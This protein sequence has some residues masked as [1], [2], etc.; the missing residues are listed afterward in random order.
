MK[1]PQGGRWIAVRVQ[2]SAGEFHI[3]V[4]HRH[5]WRSLLCCLHPLLH[6]QFL[7]QALLQ[8]TDETWVGGAGHA[9]A[10]LAIGADFYANCSHGLCPA[11]YCHT[12][13]LTIPARSC[14]L[15]YGTIEVLYNAF[16]L[17]SN[18]RCLQQASWTLVSL[19][20]W[21]F[22]EDLSLR[23]FIN[24]LIEDAWSGGAVLS[25]EEQY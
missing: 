22:V 25:T 24:K 9:G 20:E 19:K 15:R 8:A 21:V 2:S 16:M 11:M 10:R 23:H 12:E 14:Y 1:Q 17:H 3:A 18:K 13:L 4:Q 5:Q 7:H 6:G